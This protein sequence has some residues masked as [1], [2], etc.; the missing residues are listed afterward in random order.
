MRIIRHKH[1]FF[2]LFCFLV[3]A[4][5]VTVY[6]FYNHDSVLWSFRS[7]KVTK[8]NLTHILEDAKVP[9]YYPKEI[10]IFLNGKLET[11]YVEY[12]LDVELQEFMENLFSSYQP[13][14]AAFVALDP[15]TGKI[16]SLISYAKI[17]SKL[18]ENLA[19]KASYPAASIFK[20]VTASAAIGEKN[21]T[22][23]TII[24]FNGANHTLYR[25]NILQSKFT[26][27]TRYM[28]LKDAFAK[29]VNTVFGKI[30]AFSLGSDGLR[31]YADRFGFNRKIT[32]DLPV[33]E[34]K[35][36]IPNDAW[37]LAESASG[38]TQ[39]NTMSP[40]QG[41]L[42]VSAIVN[43]GVM[44]EPYL[45]QLL[46]LKSGKSLYTALPHELGQTLDQKTALEMRELMRETIRIGTS[47][48][49]FR[50]FSRGR[51][52]GMDIG[53]KTG[54]LSGKNPKGKYDWFIGYAEKN[55][56]PLALSVLTIHEKYWKVKSSYLGR[57]AI[58]RYFLDK[59]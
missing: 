24:P 18:N 22:A 47:R 52:T 39:N 40:L 28:S 44:M 35:A 10:D 17:H 33:G 58:E 46:S 11:T 20:I 41:A 23:N 55:N 12:T 26:R 56:Q 25:S 1:T 15:K 49:S 53:G 9:Q 43:Q 45:V 3:F 30:G 29:S 8:D 50:G 57:R 59:N 31:E 32:G 36:I 54:S 16:L 27:F 13:D 51:F 5:M 2:V 14:Y 7:P 48:R 21:F 42:M 34:S 38:F 6:K 4:V 37:G 19:L